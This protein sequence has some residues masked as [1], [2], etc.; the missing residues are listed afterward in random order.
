MKR[1]FSDTIGFGACKMMRRIFGLAKVA[2]IANIQDLDERAKIERMVLHMAKE[3][4]IHREEYSSIEELVDLA[5]E[6]SPLV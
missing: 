6:I 3:I 5:K 2:D 4:V 1:I